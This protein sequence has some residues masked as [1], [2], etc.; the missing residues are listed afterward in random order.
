MAKAK[1]TKR[2]ATAKAKPKKTAKPKPKR[3]PKQIRVLPVKDGDSTHPIASIWRPTLEAIVQALA[4]GNFSLSG[5]PSVAPVSKSTA[6]H[7]RDYIADY[8]ETL[9]PLPAATWRSSFAQ[10]LDGLWDITVDLWT[11]ESGRS[12]M[13][14]SSQVFE[15][16]DGYRFKVHMVYVP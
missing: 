2:K 12:D 5:V 10:W 4:R 8:G 14:L 9:A 13:V 1:A 3:R 7:M 6:K 11:K 16:D 15:V